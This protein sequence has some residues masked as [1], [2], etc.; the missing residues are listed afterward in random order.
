M[1]DPLTLLAAAAATLTCA[2]AV[3]TGRP[4]DLPA[5]YLAKAENPFADTALLPLAD[6]TNFAEFGPWS[7]GAKLTP[8]IVPAL[9]LAAAR[10]LGWHPYI[11]A[12]AGGIVLLAS[13]IV[14][15]ARATGDRFVGV[16]AGCAVAGLYAS[17]ACFAIPFQPKP[18]D[19]VALGFVGLAMLAAVS[20]PPAGLAAAVALGCLSDERAAVAAVGCG[21][22]AVFSTSAPEKLR[23]R[24]V[25][26]AVGILSWIAIRLGLGM[27]CGWSRPDGSLVDAGILR[28]TLPAAGQAA[29]VA[30]EAAAAPILLL[31]GLVARR[32]HWAV[33]A[34]WLATMV[35]SLASCLV[36]L[37]T[38]RAAAF[39]VALVPAAW[40]GL[41]FFGLQR[42]TMRSLS[43]ATAIGCILVPT[44][45][46]IAGV[47]AIPLDRWLGR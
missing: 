20:G 3:L 37:D 39:L 30:F 23:G 8:R 10:R 12:T 9:L 41:S 24:L 42:E 45:D 7:H 22:L 21:W 40:A 6:P 18:F 35:I 17:A 43:L 2:P 34:G 29:R 14:A 38:S 44:L 16:Y 28:H 47:H 36:V 31:A 19:G 11:P 15:T 46:V 25:A 27:A 5:A 32:R 1:V 33:A 13:V 26:I 4:V